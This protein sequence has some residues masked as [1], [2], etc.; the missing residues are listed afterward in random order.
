[1]DY[2]IEIAVWNLGYDEADELIEGLAEVLVE[3][4]LGGSEEED[5]QVRSIIALR[6]MGMENLDVSS[7]ARLRRM[8][9]RFTRG[10]RLL[11]IPGT[12]YRRKVEK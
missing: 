3:R 10:A 1:M 9:T 8:L 12:D 11:V 6:P 2:T 5:E 7:K 4:G